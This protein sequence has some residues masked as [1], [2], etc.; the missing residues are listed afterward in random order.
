MRPISSKPSILLQGQDT[1]LWLG[2]DQ[3]TN[4]TVISDGYRYTLNYTLPVNAWSQIELQGRGNRTFLSVRPLCGSSNAVI[5][6]EFI[7][8]V[9]TN[10][11]QAADGIAHVWLPMQFEAPIASL[12]KGFRG[13]VRSIAL[14]Q[15]GGP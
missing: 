2:H 14:R 13:H 6:H 9:D 7:T 4:V 3:H 11:V 5:E 12:G 10:S 15:Y 1:T 8:H